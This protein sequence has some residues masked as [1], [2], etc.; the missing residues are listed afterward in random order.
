ML[1]QGRT[2]LIIAIQGLEYP[3]RENLLCKFH[4]LDGS[5]PGFRS[6]TSLTLQRTLR[7]PYGVKG[8]GFKMTTLTMS[9]PGIAFS[10][11]S[12]N[13]KFQGLI[14]ATIPSGS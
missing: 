14:D 3:R 13:G 4:S 1:N 11:G 5:I 10:I 9:I 8:L 6:A 7:S 2:K 12:N